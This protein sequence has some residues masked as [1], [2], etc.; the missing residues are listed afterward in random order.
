MVNEAI[1]LIKSPRTT[2]EQIN[3]AKEIFTSNPNL[4]HP[5]LVSGSDK[6]SRVT[7]EQTSSA[8]AGK[9][10]KQIQHEDS[11]VQH[12]DLYQEQIQEFFER[13]NVAEDKKASLQK[14][15]EEQKAILAPKTQN[16]AENQLM[17]LDKKIQDVRGNAKIPENKKSAYI[18]QLE[19]QKT[20][21]KAKPQNETAKL[22]DKA[23]NLLAQQIEHHI[24]IPN[25]NFEFNSFLNSQI[26][27]RL[28]IEATPEL[29]QTLNFDK[30]YLPNLFSTLSDSD[31]SEQFTKLIELIKENP[32]KPLSELRET[33]EHNGQT[34]K[35]FEQN[36]INYHKWIKFDKNS[37]LPFSCETDLAEA[38][39]GVELNI[40]NELNGDL[41]KSVE[42]INKEQTDKILQALA[43]AGYKINSDS[44]T[45]G[46]NGDG[47]EITQKDLEKIVG[48][49]KDTINQNPE[50]WDKPLADRNAE[51]LKNELIIHLLKVHKKAVSDLQSMANVKMDLQVRLTDDNDIGRNL[52]LGSHVG[53][54]TSV[55]ATGVDN[56][57]A[58]PQH[59]MNTF[60][61]AIEIVDKGGNS[62]GNSMCYFAKIDGKLSFVVD[63]FEANGKLGGN[64]V[65]TD[66]IVQYAKQVTSEMVK[67]DKGANIPIVFGP[68]Y[69]K[70]NMS[71]LKRTSDHTVEAI[72]RVEDS[73]YIDA[74]GGNSDV[75]TLHKNRSLYTF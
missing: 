63:S 8:T 22:S 6:Y 36:G 67:S 71:K 25:N 62:Y 2:V 58:A 65:V 11:G 12:Y 44:V 20:E 39:Q 37:H 32:S 30:Q 38:I 1:S 41:F 54:C 19:K 4:R 49:F 74:I 34:K 13:F 68:N 61:R 23:L 21:L 48:I 55:G 51:S 40:V 73:T 16:S 50:F 57:F 52:F 72:G 53:C 43:N 66:S 17:I 42:K 24:N 9:I 28:H 75:N 45:K 46:V 33:L 69:N 60:V 56:S 31:F 7:L 64:Q 5:E 26:Y 10:L 70:I 14:F 47:Q 15:F 27:K 3:L 29:L 18:E 35:L 59:L